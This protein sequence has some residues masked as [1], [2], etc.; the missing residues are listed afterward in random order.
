MPDCWCTDNEFLNLGFGEYEEHAVLLCNYFNYIDRKK[1]KN[2]VSYLVIGD[3]Q[4]E[5]STIYIATMTSDFKEVELWNAKAG[6]CFYFDKTI[7]KLPFY[8]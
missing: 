6:N 1:D 2:C 5:G 7:I 8:V 3:A 4:P